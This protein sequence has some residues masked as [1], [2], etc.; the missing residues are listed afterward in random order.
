MRKIRLA[1]IFQEGMVL[2][3]EKPIYIWGNGVTGDKLHIEICKGQEVLACE[4]CEIYEEEAFVNGQG[5]FFATLPPMKELRGAM[6][7]IYA[8]EEEQPAIVIEDISIGD[9]YLAGGQSN[10]EYFLR[11]EAHFNDLNK[12]AEN[13]DIHMYN[14]PQIAYE[15]QVRDLP[16]YGYWFTKNDSAWRVFSSIGYLFAQYIQLETGVP[17]GIIGCNWGGTPACAWIEE[18]I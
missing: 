7:K 12:E 9:V 17:V 1:D 2:Q 10:M 11:Y 4:S 18:N 6:L 15:G 14:V 3:R 13:L 16:D 5:N 8:N